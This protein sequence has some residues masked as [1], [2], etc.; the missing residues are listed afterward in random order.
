[1]VICYLIGELIVYGLFRKELALFPRYVTGVDYNGFKIRQNV[2]NAMYRHKSY[3]GEW[4]FRI[5]SK[6]FRSD[7]EYTYDKPKDTVRILVLGDSYTIGHEVNQDE[8]YSMALEKSLKAKGISAEV[9]NAGVSGFGNSEELI[10]YEQEGIKYNPDILILGFYNNDLRDNMRTGLYRLDNDNLV[11]NSK[12]YQPYIKERDFLNSFYIYRWLGEYSYLHNYLNAVATDFLKRDVVVN[13]VN[14][15][16]QVNPT[17]KKTAT[18]TREIIPQNEMNDYGYE[19]RLAC[20]LV[21]KIKEIA[22]QHSTR[23]ILL[24]VALY[25]PE[26]QGDNLSPSFP[27]QCIGNGTYDYYVNS[28]ELLKQYKGSRDDLYRPHG[29]KHWTEKSHLIVGQYLAGLV[30]EILKGDFHK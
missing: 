28:Y 29:K 6:G 1:M 22:A 24:D 12:E 30:E 3:D 13:N 19:V 27:K 10:F 2:P 7:V 4:K 9:I 15:M 14:E 16:I 20:K 18:D 11:Q 21:E 17:L 5:N 23:F 8:T 25:I 26:A